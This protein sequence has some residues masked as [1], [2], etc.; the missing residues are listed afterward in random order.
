[1]LKEIALTGVY[2]APIV[3]YLL[4]TLP[5]FLVCR[6]LLGRLGVLGFVWHPSLF[7]VALFVTLLSLMVSLR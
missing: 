1:M 2:V 3:I 6:W 7:E 5:L 4:L